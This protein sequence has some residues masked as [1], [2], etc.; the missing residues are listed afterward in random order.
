MSNIKKNFAYQSLYQLLLLLL[1]F[2][3][4]PYISRVL[5]SSGVGIYTYATSVTSYFVLIIN[6]GIE[7]YGNREVAKIKNNK[8]NLSKFVSNLILLHVLLGIVVTS[9]FALYTVFCIHEN[10]DIFIIS[11]LTLLATT[12]DINWLFFG[13][14]EFKL[15]VTRSIV[16]KLATV[17]C[18]FLLVKSPADLIKYTL[19]MNA[20]NLISQIVLW[21]NLRKKVELTRPSLKKAIQNLRPMLVLFIP[22]VALSIYRQ[23]DKVMLGIMSSYSE[24]G[25]YEYSEKIINAPVG[26][27][28][29]LGIV[30]LPKMS[31]LYDEDSESALKYVSFS[32]SFIMFIAFGCAFGIIAVADNFLPL[33]FGADFYGTVLVTK[34]LAITIPLLAWSNVIRNQFLLPRKK[35]FFYVGSMIAGAV[36]NLTINWILIPNYGAIGAAIATLFTQI[37]ITI[38]QSAG[39]V[40]E[41]ELL[42][43]FKKILYF[44]VTSFIMYGCVKYMG[45][46]M[47][48]TFLSILIRCC[49][50]MIVYCG[51]NF[52]L[53]ISLAKSVVKK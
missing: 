46:Y 13:L 35:D 36:M 52:K 27:I 28:S 4:A 7:T 49:V 41:L 48:N 14:E 12:I 40:K 5:G 6:L 33:F 32:M 31:H 19:L 11:S 51:L 39:A 38:V 26:L 15:T 42:R 30:M 9:V 53:S 1:P 8:S 44:A 24:V 43:Y 47:H 3:T 10:Q 2:V 20:A 45:N 21:T 18:I 50:G 23:M 17:G 25:I 37:I 22:A 34:L 16:I 29:A